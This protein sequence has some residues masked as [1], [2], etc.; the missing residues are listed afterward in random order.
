MIERYTRPEMQR[1]WSDETRLRRMLEV[2]LAYLKALARAKRIPS[3][4][5]D[6]LRALLD[7][8]LAEQVKNREAKSGH[9][10]IG[11]LQAVSSQVKAKAPQLNRY[12]HYGLTSSDVLDTG[13]SLQLVEANSLLLDSWRAVAGRIR[14]LAEQHKDTWMVG[15]T[16]GVHAEPITFGVKVAGWHAEALR[17]I[18]R[19]ERARQLSSFGKISGAVGT[20]AHFPVAFEAEVC[21]ELG[22]APEP[23]STQVVPRDRY[24]DVYHAWV[25]TA[26]AIERIALEIRHLQKTEVLEAEEPFTEDQKG[27]SAMP[28]KRNPVLCENLC[29][30]A[31]LIRTYESAVVENCALWHERDISHSSNERVIFPDA[32]IAL[33]FMIHRLGQVLDGLQVY[34][35]RMRE[36]MERS[37]GLVYS[38]KVL[39]QLIDAGLGRLEAYELVQRN[40][41]KTWKARRPFLEF[42][43]ADP[44]VT[45]RLPAGRL[46]ACFDLKSY[47]GAIEEILRRGGVTARKKAGAR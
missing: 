2:E 27:S 29:G 19:L 36:N 23:V 13:F 30:L 26:A 41:M 18:E 15:R 46:R 1:V 24:A 34:P 6:A 10:V 9:E 8:A 45:R 43:L 38:Q 4:E 47:G 12:L 33:H 21:R 7:H 37:L 32:A 3:A 11:L 25:L 20:F 39:L 14:S 35:D 22:L 28:H 16:H 5:L 40:A 44:D 31:R 17:N 42:L